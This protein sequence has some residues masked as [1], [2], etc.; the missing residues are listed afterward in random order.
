VEPEGD[1]GEDHYE[2][3]RDVDLDDVVAEGADEVELESQAGIV[4]WI[5]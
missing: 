5:N 3:G 4:T 1:P 2:A